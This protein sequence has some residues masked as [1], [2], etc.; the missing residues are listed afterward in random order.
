[1]NHAEY[2]LQVSVCEYLNTQ[3][4]NV[5]Y[6]SDT[7]AAVKLTP[8]QGYRNKQI[9]K[10]EFK[11]PDL[12]ILQPNAMDHGLFIELKIKS[13]YKANGELYKDE[14]LE[15]QQR[16][17]DD[18]NALG[19]YACFAWTFEMCKEIIDRYMMTV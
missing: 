11:T 2:K 16:A 19:Y 13:P 14:H 3:Y 4:P 1:M 12:T 17:I 7:I 5:K 18:L 10:D 15:G 6:Y 8:M 9:Q